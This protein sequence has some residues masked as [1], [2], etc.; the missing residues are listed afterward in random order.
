MSMNPQPSPQPMRPALSPV[1]TATPHQPEQQADREAI[2]RGG[3]WFYW[4]AG[5]SLVNTI[6]NAS[7]ASIVMI[8]GLGASLLLNALGDAFGLAGQIVAY[9]LEFLLLAFYCAMG[10][11]ACRG[12]GWAF[13]LGIAAYAA[14]ALITL[15]LQDWLMAAVHGY[16][17][18]QLVQGLR[19]SLASDRN[20]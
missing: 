17:L 4:L 18:F 16:V 6:L 10:V 8:F 20:A 7:G 19:A 3:S 13:A 9:S 1:E 14:D 15:A 5:L 12:H 2:S 11:L